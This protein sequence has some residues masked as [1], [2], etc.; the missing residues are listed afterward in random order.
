[1]KAGTL[2]QRVTILMPTYASSTQSDQGVASY[3]ATDTVWASVKAL[4]GSE[5]LAAQSITSE[6]QYEIEM[7]FRPEVT[8]KYRLS[9]TPFSGTAKTFEVH[10]VQVGQRQNGGMVLLCGVRE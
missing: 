3:S 10:A 5:L 9:W 1:M 7:R 8:P 4:G 2:D 6:V